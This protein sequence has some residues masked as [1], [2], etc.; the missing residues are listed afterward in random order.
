MRSPIIAGMISLF[1]LLGLGTPSYALDG[2]TLFPACVSLLSKAEIVGEY[3]KIPADFKAHECWAFFEAIDGMIGFLE[4][5][6]KTRVLGI[7]PPN[8]VTKTQMMRVFTVWAAKHPER[9][10]ED[11]AFSSVS[12]LQE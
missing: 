6:G 11:A 9:M 4:A 8:G 7:C 2:N 5:D 12:S 3:L 10:H 1:P